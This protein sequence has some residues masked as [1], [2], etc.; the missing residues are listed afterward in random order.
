MARDRGIYQPEP[1]REQPPPRRYR[2]P[3][4]PTATAEAGELD[5]GPGLVPGHNNGK[6]PSEGGMYLPKCPPVELYGNSLTPRQ[7]RRPKGEMRGYP[8]DRFG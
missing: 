7:Q 1:W 5:W 8:G 4:D 6:P 2:R 3:R